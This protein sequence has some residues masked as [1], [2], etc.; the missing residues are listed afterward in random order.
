MT[1]L[2]LHAKSRRYYLRIMIAGKIYFRSTGKTN[3]RDA[4]RVKQKMIQ[5]IRE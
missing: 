4:E 1:N 2:V 3:K 5:Q